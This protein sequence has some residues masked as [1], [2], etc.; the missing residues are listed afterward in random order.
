M[1]ADSDAFKV[2]QSLPGFTDAERQYL[3]TVSRGEGFYGLGWGHPSKS[4]IELSE[5]FGID[6]RAGVGSNNWGAEQGQGSNGSFPHV[7]HHANGKPY[8]EQYKKH[9]TPAE[10]AASVA[11]ILLK[12]NVKAAVNAGDLKAAVY[13]QHSNGYF[14]LDPEKYLSAVKRNYDI[15]TASLKWPTLL[16][17]R[18]TIATAPLA[19]FSGLPPSELP[20]TSSGQPSRLPVL[21][22]GSV[23]MHVRTLQKLLNEHR[24]SIR[25][26]GDF[27]PITDWA[28]RAFQ[29]S[30]HIKVDGIVGPA[31]WS[32]LNG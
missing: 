28:V 11:R 16:Q 31:T 18:E 10:G 19:P 3:L 7:D 9:K 26:D 2:V 21:N 20:S 25:V 29:H 1:T 30:E 32:R 5:E 13:A 15:L 4:T 23:G 24:Y 8:V 17:L 6:P 22:L 14:E 12:P 27:G